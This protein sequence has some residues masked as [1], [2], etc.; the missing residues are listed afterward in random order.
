MYWQ[1]NAYDDGY[2]FKES[3]QKTGLTGSPA[4]YDI[5][6]YAGFTLNTDLSNNPPVFIQGDGSAVVNVYYSRGRY[7]VIFLDNN[8]NHV[9][10]TYTNVKQ[11][12]YIIAIWDEMHR[13]FDQY[14]WY[15]HTNNQEHYTFAPLMPASDLTLYG[16]A[17]GSVPYTIYYLE[18]IHN[19]NIRPPYSFTAIPTSS[20]RPMTTSSSPASR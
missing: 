16:N 9:I 3:V 20:S 18:N 7:N 8:D 12:M 15:T 19:V 13:D 4:I 5:K 2:S 10:R 1:E 17:K 14:T 11:G 6:T